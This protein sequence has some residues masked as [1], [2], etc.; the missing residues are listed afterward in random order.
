MSPSLNSKGIMI[1]CSGVYW[2]TLRSKRS[3]LKF[4]A[5]L[6]YVSMCIF[7]NCHQ[8]SHH[9]LSHCHA[10]QVP[11]MQRKSKPGHSCCLLLSRILTLTVYPN[12]N[13]VIVQL[14]FESA[15][16]MRFVK[17]WSKNGQVGWNDV[18][19]AKFC[20]IKNWEDVYQITM[21]VLFG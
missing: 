19:L 10:W 1:F 13:W 12:D 8:L 20:K 4:H 5:P 6:Q 2:K 17:S 7:V 11:I 9:I 18:F 16:A 15:H 14:E 21:I 3:Q